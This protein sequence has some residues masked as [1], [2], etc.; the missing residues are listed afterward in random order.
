MDFIVQDLR[1]FPGVGWSLVEVALR[2]RSI[3]LRNMAVRALDAWGKP[4]WPPEAPRLVREAM[5]REPR[6]E[7]RET[8]EA[9]L[10]GR[11]IA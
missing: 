6:E 2:G 11:P 8:F 5:A 9:I 10:A 1:R 7:L 4:N 3:R